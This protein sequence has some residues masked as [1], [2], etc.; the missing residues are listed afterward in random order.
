MGR[1]SPPDRVVVM[2]VAG[3]GK[4]TVAAALADRLGASFIEADDHH[5]ASNVE[6][7]AAGI[8]LTDDDRWPWLASIRRAMRA[9][10]DV[11]VACSALRR[12]YRDALRA[13][14]GVRFCYLDVDRAEAHRRVADRPGH[15]MG[16]AMVDSQFETLEA[17]EATEV[18]VVTIDAA[19]DADA[20]IAAA[21]ASLATLEVGTAIMPLRSVGDAGNEIS[22]AELRDLVAAVAERDV[23]GAG[24][25]RVLLVPP[26]RTRLHSRGGE[27]TG[28]LYEDLVRAGCDVTVLPALGTHA[29]MDRDDVEQLFVGRVPFERVAVHRWRDGLAHLGEISAA[30]VS[31]LSGGAI[32]APIPVDVSEVLLQEWDLVVS[33]GQVVPH[34]VIGMANYSKNLVIG[35][36]GAATINRSHF[37]GAVCGM[38]RIMGRPLGPVRDVVDAAFDRFVARRVEVLWILTVVEDAPDGTVQRGLFVGR[39]GSGASGGAAYRAAAALAAACNIDIVDEPVGRVACWLD[40][41]EFRSTWLANKAIYRTRMAIA[42]GGELVVLAPG[43]SRFGEDPSLDALI[44]RHGYHGTAATLDA[45]ASDPEL[46]DNLGAAAHLIHSSSE[47]RFSITYCTDP[48]TGGLSREE[49]VG[50]GYDWRPLA[51]E[52]ERLGVSAATPTGRRADAAGASFLHIANPALGLW[53]MR[54]RLV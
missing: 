1:V 24:A 21:L 26:D 50:A 16:A 38:E 9:E 33:V 6:K 48:S 8:A 29:A 31:A 12:S 30:E 28:L 42:D 54:D 13:A 15:F 19:G 39:G 2:G 53:A 3:C 18:D 23:V 40:P 49:V 47:G 22:H 52:L 35:L 5:P 34:E 14:G 46:A 7:M 44:R 4:S 20:V 17:P 41:V 37:L 36:G 25:R 10:H 43:V 45:L 51:T 27:I 32:T 11:V